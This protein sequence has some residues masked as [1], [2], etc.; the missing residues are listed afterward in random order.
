[1]LAMS[2]V[3]RVSPASAQ[4]NLLANATFDSPGARNSPAGYYLCGPGYRD[5][6]GWKVTRGSVKVVA[7][8]RAPET[9]Q[10][11]DLVGQSPGTIEQSFPT[12]PGQYY[13]FAG[14]LAHNPLNPQTPE[15]RAD[16]SVDGVIVTRLVHR[17][18]DTT[19]T[20]M[21]WVRFQQWFR[22]SAATTTLAIAD[23]TGTA[24][25]GGLALASLSVTPAPFP[26]NVLHG[27]DFEGWKEFVDTPFIWVPHN[28]LIDG[29]KQVLGNAALSQSIGWQQIQ[30][31]QSIALAAPVSPVAVYG[32]LP[33]GPG[34]LEHYLVTEPGRV[35]TISGWMAH[36]PSVS[37]GRAYIVV[38]GQVVGQVVHSNALYGT[39]TPEDM[40][41]Q[42]FAL[43]FRAR[44]WAT[45]LLLTAVTQTPPQERGP[46]LDDLVVTPDP[47]PPASPQPASASSVPPAPVDL[48]AFVA[49]GPKIDL[50][51]IDQSGNETAFAVW[52]RTETEDWTRIAVLPPNSTT[53][54]DTTVSSGV[55]YT[56][57]VRAV[58]NQGASDW[59]NEFR[60]FTPETPAAPSDLIAQEVT[61]SMINLFWKANSQDETGFLIW[62]KL[63]VGDGYYPWAVVPAHQTWYTDIG[64]DEWQFFPC[65]TYSYAVTAINR[66]GVS[67]FSNRAVVET[68][69]P[70]PAAPAK[71]QVSFLNGVS[72]RF[73]WQDN[74]N[75]EG[76]FAVWGRKDG[77]DYQLITGSEP[78]QTFAFAYDLAPNTTY[79]FRVRADNQCTSSDWSNEVTVRTRAGR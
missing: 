32:E 44:Y 55:A 56:Y 48:T 4:Q 25:A 13:L 77:G 76:R 10:S 5:L 75:N 21:H 33:M 7:Y 30:G 38:D 58:N 70:I 57:R 43:R 1:V 41:W 53:Y 39:A 27:G 34:T 65:T 3:A 72:F 54:L 59:S 24:F 26:D 78:N 12:T 42:R 71:L 11:L 74:S 68:L 9:F 60:L 49:T 22:A 69:P 8:W 52:R 64:R 28:F 73:A 47:L 40:R 17:D 29:W 66:A 35:Y 67:D 18:P 62:K 46:V 79:T 51:W 16:V 2:A 50:S 31:N 63:G 23:A 15:G 6:P 19:R 45:T 14:Y 20:Q 61:P 37:E 36:D